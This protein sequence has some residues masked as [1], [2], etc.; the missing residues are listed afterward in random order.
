MKSNLFIALYLGIIT[1]TTP[2]TAAEKPL[3]VCSPDKRIELTV[4][5]DDDLAFSLVVDGKKV[6]APSKIGMTISGLETKSSKQTIKQINKGTKTETIE[7]PFYRVP[8]FDVSYNYSKIKVTDYL[9]VEFRVFN[10]GVAYRFETTGM[11]GKH[12]QV[13]DEMVS[14]CFVHDYHSYIPYSTNAKKPEAMAFQ[15]TYNV[16]RLSQQP[17][18]N[19]GFLPIT[20]ACGDEKSQELKVSLM[21]SDLES[22][23][24][25]FMRPSGNTLTGWFS[26]YPRSFDYYA[27]RVQKY[28]TST[29]DYI[30]VSQGNRTFPWRILSISR[31]DTEMPVNN[32]VYALASPNRIG[33]TSWIKPGKVAWDWWNDWGL[34]GVDFEAGINMDTYKY[35]IDFASAYGLDYIILDEGWY[36]PKRGDMLTT[37]DAIDLPELVRY[38]KEKHVRIILWTVFNVLEK[39]LETICKK[40]SEMGIAGFKVDFL[41][42]DDQEGVEMIYRIAEKCAQYHLILDYHGI[43]KPTGINRTY[44]NILNFESVFG[45]EEAKWTKHDE[46]DMPQYDVTFPF[47]RMQSGYVDFTPGGMRNATSKDF[48]PIYYNPLTMGT[49]CHQLAMY[50]IHDSPLTMLADSP[51]SYEAEPEYTKF[52]ADI[53]TVFDEVRVLSGQIGEYIVTAR[54]KGDVWYIGGQTNWMNRDLTVDLSELGLSGIVEAVIY[55]DG[56]NANRN[57]SDYKVVKKRLTA[58]ESMTIHLASGGGFVIQLNKTI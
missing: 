38:G 41:D 6:M 13:A 3:I 39:D 52:V 29:E 1:Q 58:S 4:S 28:V 8:Y 15:A 48:Q 17:N 44:P 33:D 7:S 32:L 40:Y 24:G 42:R 30:A 26:K 18:D 57:A 12:Y 54:R 10:D 27:W 55:K 25:M 45:M 5:F 31:K 16:E 23:P 14:Y 34:T 9:C 19:L 22:Y 36:E 56:V 21:E 47:I 53:P 37:I 2:L 46:K 20:I 11:E 50:V 43:Y 49:R 35:Y 51:T